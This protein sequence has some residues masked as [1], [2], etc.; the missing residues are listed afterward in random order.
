[1]DIPN[2]VKLIINANIN[3]G[4]TAIQYATHSW[5]D[6]QNYYLLLLK[7]SVSCGVLIAFSSVINSKTVTN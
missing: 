6:Y 7:M 3:V 4:N 5:E 1:M 2:K